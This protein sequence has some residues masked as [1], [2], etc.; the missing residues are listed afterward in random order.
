MARAHN[1][2]VNFL[3]RSSDLLSE[4]GSGKTI[5]HVVK[6]KFCV[7]LVTGHALSHPIYAT[8]SNCTLSLQ[9]S[10]IPAFSD[11]SNLAV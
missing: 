2:N 1:Y 8:H 5:C 4:C 7:T 11:A 3:A 10:V 6:V 9:A